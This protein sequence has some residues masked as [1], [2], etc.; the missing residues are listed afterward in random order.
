MFGKLEFLPPDPILGVTAAF[1]RDPD[2]SKV[3]LGV[4]V[5]R[6][7]RG[8]TPLPVAVVEAEQQLLAEQT[9]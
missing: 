9:T 8:S 5:Y 7:E 2:P 3:D 1:R 4:G 6:N